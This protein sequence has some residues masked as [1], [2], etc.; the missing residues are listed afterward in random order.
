[1]VEEG[2]KRIAHTEVIMHD[3]YAGHAQAHATVAGKMWSSRRMTEAG[4]N[5]AG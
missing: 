4:K 5:D 2:E 3:R 1:M